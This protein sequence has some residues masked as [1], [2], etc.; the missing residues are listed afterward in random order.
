M[1]IG[2]IF[3]LHEDNFTTT[4]GIT[5]NTFERSI[6][7]NS[8][9]RGVV[10]GLLLRSIARRRV[11]ECRE[12]GLWSLDSWA[13]VSNRDDPHH[14]LRN[15]IWT[16]QS[17]LLPR[18]SLFSRREIY[19]LIIWVGSNT[20]LSLVKTQMEVL[21]NQHD[22][23]DMNRI[24]GWAAYE[25]TYPCR[26][27]STLCKRNETTGDF[28]RLGGMPNNYMH[29][30]G[31]GWNC[32]QRRQLRAMS[33]ALLL[34]DPDFLL[35][36]DDDTYVNV[37]L[38]TYGTTLSKYILTE[39]KINPIVYGQLLNMEHYMSNVGFYCG[40]AGYLMGRAVVDRLVSYTL[41]GR[42]AESD[43]Y[44]N[45]YVMKNLEV[46][47]EVV[48]AINTTTECSNCKIDENGTNVTLCVRVIEICANLISGENTCSH[49][50]HAVSRCL[51][52]GVYATQL[53]VT[54]YD[55]KISK[56][57]HPNLKLGMCQSRRKG[58]CTND[59]LLTCHQM[60]PFDEKNP[61][62]RAVGLIRG[63]RVAM[64]PTS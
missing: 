50:D 54:C 31:A 60:M 48:K 29:K 22:Y 18:N 9:N 10:L 47:S 34:Y 3:S 6:E 27:G 46:L 8:G 45:S 53:G 17:Y 16:D 26:V 38:I 19:G 37:K 24:F 28:F 58:N 21:R 59:Y 36:V 61:L 12:R 35:V 63:E 64:K 41:R 11:E 42:P 57:A 1:N 2:E 25:D 44:R 33:H 4:N 49:S 56:T 62:N 14:I 39:M 43:K 20:K 55:K 13:A 7:D 5:R 51:I 15:T 30:N 52:H 32:A 40:G 23:N